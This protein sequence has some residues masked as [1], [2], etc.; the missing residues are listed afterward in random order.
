MTT[1]ALSAAKTIITPICPACGCSLIRLGI[2]SDRWAKLIYEGKEYFCCC[3]DCADLFNQDPAKY[4]KEIKDWVVC[5]T[6]LA[7]NRC[8]RP[9]AWKLPDGKYFFVDALIARKCFKKTLIT[10]SNVYKLRFHMMVYSV[11][12][13]MVSRKSKKGKYLVLGIT[14][15]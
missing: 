14:L 5:P 12:L 13:G 11:K 8:N 4:L 2:G 3:Q 7:E 15:G 10:M 6:C 1:N 9:Y